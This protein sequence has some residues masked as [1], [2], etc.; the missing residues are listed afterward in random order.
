MVI[1]AKQSSVTW[2]LAA[3]FLLSA[4]AVMAAG[5]AMPGR[6]AAPAFVVT[7]P[8][9]EYL[10]NF[11]LAYESPDD[12]FFTHL[13]S[14]TAEASYDDVK[15]F[16]A[17]I[18]YVN[19]PWRYAGVIL[20][21]KGS[22]EKIRV[23]ENGFQI[24]A[25]LTRR[26]PIDSNA[27]TPGDTHLW[28]TVGA[29]DE[30]FGLDEARQGKPQYEGGYLPVLETEYT[31]DGTV[32]EEKVFAA[33]LV[34][35][36]R[37]PL[38]DEPGIS[39]YVRVT[40]KNAPGQV[41]FELKA[42]GVGYGFP[43]V[44]AGFRHDS[45][46]DE[47]NNVYAYFSGG[48]VYDEKSK[49]VRFRLK[50]GQSAYVVLPHQLQLA[51]THAEASARSFEQARARVVE[52]W[53]KEL[54]LGG[55][56]DVPEKVVMNAYRSLLIGDWQVSIGDELPYGMFSWYE[57]N[58]YAESLQS[59]APFIEYGYF[60]DARRFI[61]P[62]LE[63]PLSDTGIGLHVCANRLELAA[64]YYAFSRDADFIRRNKDRLVEVADYLL[65]HRDPKTGLV[66]DGYGFD[67]ADQQVVNINTNSNG[68]RA[69]RNLGLT[70]RAI[71]EEKLGDKYLAIA[72]TFGDEVR[73]AIL[74][75]IDHSTT[76]PFVAFA[77][78]SEKPYKSLVESRASSYYNIVMPYFFES[79]IFAPRAE[80]YTDT[81]EYMW[82]HR[83]VMAGLNRFNG[84]GPLFGQDGIHPL[85]SWGRQ[86][87]QI[88]RHETRRA[89]YT[90]YS[91]LAHGYTR[92]TFLTGE[93]QGAK[94]NPA[95][96]YRGTYLPPEPPANALLLRS[97]R[98]MLIHENDLNQD[99]IYEELWLLSS[100]PAS[101]LAPGKTVELRNMPS[102]IGAVSLRI[103]ADPAGRRLTADLRLSPLASGSVALYVRGYRVLR[104][105]GAAGQ[106]LKVEN[107]DGDSVVL[108]PASPGNQRL[109]IETMSERIGVSAK[110]R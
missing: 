55:T 47:H 70:F 59:I 66:M 106:T 25:G 88:S 19:A 80:A 35:R 76:P 109:V 31:V 43:I 72:K 82:T 37:S 11:R 21:P 71:G 40:A 58:G 104:A 89:I 5:Q 99:G 78:G 95:E 36:Y 86:F 63:Y 51:G 101:W 64:Y 24:D 79:E 29:G 56:I 8:S 46:T 44:N 26:S 53:R 65:R 100:A 85:Y 60:S 68:W 74:R 6:G 42:P 93:S 38:V 92:G 50:A 54:A 52:Q 18:R 45:W 102:R 14:R 103:Q 67:L 94:P 20:S 15:G 17:P 22:S 73:A 10:Q 4:S 12:Y 96:W 3:I 33:P 41:G 75:N 34:A 69:V 61:Q 83:G 97:L 62:I 98:H 110:G 105:T 49:L 39:A 91:S 13:P 27:W 57:G 108:I 81:L 107:R 1:A 77:L 48:G 9:A 84:Y 23:V 7:K 90:F 32:Y 2:R 30:L 28:V 16:L 87:S